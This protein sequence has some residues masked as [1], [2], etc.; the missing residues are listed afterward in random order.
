MSFSTKT[1]PEYVRTRSLK[2]IK[3]KQRINKKTRSIIAACTFDKLYAYKIFSSS[4]NSQHFGAFILELITFALKQNILLKDIIII[5]DN[6]PTH[7]AASLKELRNSVYFLFLPPYRPD[8]NLIERVFSLWKIA[9]KQKLYNNNNSDLEQ[10]AHDAALKINRFGYLRKAK[11][12]LETY[13]E[14][15]S[16][17]T[18]ENIV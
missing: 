4:I 18:P 12:Q 11:E 14:A 7:R 8:L 13:Y 1:K 16:S 15:L 2:H 9:I 3:I 17:D 6:A 10:V 5:L